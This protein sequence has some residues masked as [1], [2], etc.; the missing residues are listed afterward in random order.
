M[1]SG[2]T[3]GSRSRATGTPTGTS[4]TIS[5][6]RRKSSS[7]A[8][9]SAMPTWYVA[10]ETRREVTVA[11]TGDAGDELFAGYDRYRAVALANLLDQLPARSQT[12]LGGPIARALPV[13]VRAKTR[14]RK[15]R[16][17]LEAI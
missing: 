14:L 6:L 16:R 8:R 13:S 17:V 11:L 4:N 7:F 15:V 2:R 3:G 12:M 5:R 1:P 9:P 10:R